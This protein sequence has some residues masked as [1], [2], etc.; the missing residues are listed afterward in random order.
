MTHKTRRTSFLATLF[1]AGGLAL[2]ASADEGGVA[3]WFSGQY[4]SFAAVPATPGWSVPI[5]GYRYGGGASGSKQLK[6]GN[7]ATANLNST[8]PLLMAQ[9]TYAPETKLWGGQLAIGLGF[10]WGN[11]T[12][13]AGLAVTGITTELDRS[14]SVTGFT[15]LYPIVSLA[16]NEGNNNWMTYITGD[17]PTGDY[18]S[19]RLA[20]IGIGHGAVDVGGGIPILTQQRASSFPLSWASPTTLKTATRGIGTGSTHT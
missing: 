16:W 12:T 5:Q 3:F 4:G 19:S 1:L 14:D 6:R 15:D 20:N 2:P 11:N 10:G 13:D 8:V 9:P 18:D 17:I 7:T